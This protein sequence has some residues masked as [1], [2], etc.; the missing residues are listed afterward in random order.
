MSPRSPA[1][2]PGVPPPPRT[3]ACPPPPPAPAALQFGRLPLEGDMRR[4]GA[5]CAFYRLILHRPAQNLMQ[6]TGS[7]G[8]RS[9]HQ[10]P[11]TKQ[12]SVSFAFSPGLIF[13]ITKAIDVI[14]ANLAN[15]GT[16]EKGDPSDMDC[17]LG[18]PAGSLTAV[19][20]THTTRLALRP[21]VT[22]TGT[23]RKGLC[24][25]IL[26]PSLSP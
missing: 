26:S 8:D 9:G 16:H 1:P 11:A 17:P 10:V 23:V 7:R 4:A 3:L 2:T 14:C 5:R 25:V 13:L 21:W 22:V 24:F 12:G 19:P 15:T 6:G 20:G 18:L